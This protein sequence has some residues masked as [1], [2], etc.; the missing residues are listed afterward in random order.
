MEIDSKFQTRVYT[1]Q[2]KVQFSIYQKVD[3]IFPQSMIKMLALD[4]L[5]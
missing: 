1:M 2:K 3:N 4:K 5:P